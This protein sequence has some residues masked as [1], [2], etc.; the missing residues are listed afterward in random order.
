MGGNAWERRSHARHFCN[1]AFRGLQ[2]RFSHGNA[3]S[4]AG[5]RECNFSICQKFHFRIFRHGFLISK[6]VR[7]G[8]HGIPVL[9]PAPKAETSIS[10]YQF[11]LFDLSASWVCRRVVQLPATSGLAQTAQPRQNVGTTTL[12]TYIFPG[13]RKW[14]QIT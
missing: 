3:R 13:A 2:Q 8:R 11:L 1:P 14:L 5:K 4:Q 7:A 12:T 9:A 6:H 10:L